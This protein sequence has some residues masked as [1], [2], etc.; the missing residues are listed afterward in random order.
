HPTLPDGHPA[1]PEGH[2]EI[3]PA[4]EPDGVPE[5]VTLEAWGIEFR[6]LTSRERDLYNVRSGAFVDDLAEGGAAALGGVPIGTVVTSIE[7]EDGRPR[8][9]RSAEQAAQALAL[10]EVGSGDALVE[11][12]RPDGTVG[13][14]ELRLR[15]E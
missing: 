15:A 4:P 6:D 13:F 5:S 1:L 7:L 10:A 14:Y 3:G 9:I 8:R 11:V 2:P 12:R